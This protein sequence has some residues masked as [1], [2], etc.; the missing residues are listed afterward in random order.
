MLF[1]FY[2]L[3]TSCNK[4]KDVPREKT[5]LDVRF[6][7]YFLYPF[8][9]LSY[10]YLVFLSLQQKIK[11]PEKKKK[12]IITFYYFFLTIIIILNIIVYVTK[13]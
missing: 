9:L 7:F 10:T 11:L 13:P 12:K 1:E 5:S 6:F 4:K 2:H 8:R 3:H